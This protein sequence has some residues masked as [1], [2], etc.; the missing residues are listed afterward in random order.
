[1]T[2][3]AALVALY[4]LAAAPEPVVDAPVMAALRGE[5]VPTARPDI[6]AVL[7]RLAPTRRRR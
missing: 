2:G 6:A 5:P 1:V 4:C 3:P 7:I